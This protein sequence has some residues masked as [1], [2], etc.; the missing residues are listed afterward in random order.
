MNKF[1][2]QVY[3]K[4][5][6]MRDFKST[7]SLKLNQEDY[8]NIINLP[9]TSQA[10]RP[11]IAEK[12]LKERLIV[13]GKEGYTATFPII[14]PE[15]SVRYSNR[16]REHCIE[17]AKL[18]APLVENIEQ[19]FRAKLLLNITIGYLWQSLINRQ[20]S[21]VCGGSMVLLSNCE[22]NATLY[23]GGFGN[24]DGIFINW[25][26]TSLQKNNE[27]LNKVFN[28]KEVKRTIYSANELGEMISYGMSGELLKV[29][30]VA[31]I[32]SSAKSYIAIPILVKPHVSPQI[33]QA[34]RQVCKDLTKIGLRVI[35]ELTEVSKSTYNNC[36]EQNTVNQSSFTQALYYIYSY[37]LTAELMKQGVI[38]NINPIPVLF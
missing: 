3:N 21:K 14:T 4:E 37:E 13:K 18:I 24:G 23:I 19:N 9:K 6:F 28:N 38:P 30:K 36:G 27:Q 11:E 12:L 17:V 15:L 8:V 16:F 35:K 34:N 29:L 10:L 25:I 20:N 1:I 31:D 7:L 32:K 33:I 22:K 2:Y 5:S 26:N